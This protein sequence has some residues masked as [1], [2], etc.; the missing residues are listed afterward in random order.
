MSDQC[1]DD[2]SL[3]MQL[4]DRIVAYEKHRSGA[5]SWLEGKGYL[6]KGGRVQAKAV[7][8][9]K[10]NRGQPITEPLEW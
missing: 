3:T 6:K 2:I 4:E 10:T 1:W 9:P 7:P 8:V 5:Y